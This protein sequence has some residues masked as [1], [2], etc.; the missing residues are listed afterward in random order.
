M[1]P[2]VWARWEQNGCTLTRDNDPQEEPSRVRFRAYCTRAAFLPLPLFR[3]PLHAVRVMA[4]GQQGRTSSC[5]ELSEFPALCGVAV[6]AAQSLIAVATPRVAGI[7]SW[8][9]RRLRARP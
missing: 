5:L 2:L 8:A 9:W 1:A 6:P 7:P 4:G 3:S